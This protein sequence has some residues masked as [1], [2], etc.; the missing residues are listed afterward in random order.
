MQSV[1][2]FAL[3]AQ[4]TDRKVEKMKNVKV[5]MKYVLGVILALCFST[6]LFATPKQAE[7]IGGL[8]VPPGPH[9]SG[10]TWEN[11]YYYYFNPD[12]SMRTGWICDEY[13]MKGEWFYCYEN[14]EMA[15]DT[16]LW[17]SGYCGW[18]YLDS[19]GYMIRAT[20]RFFDNSLYWFRNNG[21]MVTGW[22]NVDT[23]VALATIWSG[24]DELGNWYDW[25]Y[26]NSSG[27]APS[28]W[29]W[30]DNG[31]YYFYYG[32]MFSGWHWIPENNA[33]FYFNRFSGKMLTGWQFL[34]EYSTDPYLG[35]PTFAYYNGELKGFWYY[36]YPDG[37][38]ATNTN[39]N[40]YWVDSAGRWW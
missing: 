20:S 22:A 2:L 5:N 15:I 18:Y 35:T 21:K 24:T 29:C 38:L 9:H 7:A 26:C 3:I 28:G 6:L 34:I 27:I 14:G 1:S 19:N 30:L 8:S 12:G 39:I 11:G 32:Q 36:F 13:D 16:W 17:D 31:W 4:T 25:I 10:K 37:S 23:E 33:W 40:G